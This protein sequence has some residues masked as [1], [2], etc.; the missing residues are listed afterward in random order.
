MADPVSDDVLTED[1]IRQVVF[2]FY[3]R[4]RAD[5]LLAPVFDGAVAADEWPHHLERM[6]DFWSSSLL[7]TGRFQG[8][9]MQ[10]HLALPELTDAHFQRWLSLFRQ[11]VRELCPAAVADRFMERALM[12]AQS[13]RLSIALN[14]GR[15]TTLMAPLK[16]TDLIPAT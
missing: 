1:L 9:P 13:F 3:D 5:G 6:C 2:G 12:I 4:V 10:K 8:R 15:D 11:T 7:K 14:A 16:E